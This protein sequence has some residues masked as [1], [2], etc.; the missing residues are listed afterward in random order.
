MIVEKKVDPGFLNFCQNYQD[1]EKKNEVE[2]DVNT[3]AA[4]AKIE[5]GFELKELAA[6]GHIN[7]MEFSKEYGALLIAYNKALLVFKN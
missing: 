5:E 1:A 4:K 6:T 2:F 7:L 3:F